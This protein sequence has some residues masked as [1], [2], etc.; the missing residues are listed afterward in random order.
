MPWLRAFY[1][2][3]AS[4]RFPSSSTPRLA[5][6][7]LENGAVIGAKL[8]TPQG[9]KAI[10]AHRGLVL[11]TGGISWNKELREKLF[12]KPAQDYS[13]APATNTGDG[14]AKALK[15]RGRPG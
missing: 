14:I 4:S 8:D 10:R 12:P 13:L 2:V 7:V 11:A 6:L 9:Q 3:S 15:I 5:D 1:S